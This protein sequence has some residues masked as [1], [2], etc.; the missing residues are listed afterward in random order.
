MIKGPL[1]PNER[2]KGISILELD[3]LFHAVLL[4]VQRQFASVIPD[5]VNDEETYSTFCLL[6][7]GA[8]SKAQNVKMD[9]TVINANNLWRK[10]MRAK[11]MKPG[12]SMME[13]YT[14]ADV[15]A[16]TLISFSSELPT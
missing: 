14:G 6:Q 3:V 13:Y 10:Q 4:G 5:H 16:P 7:R 8:S 2:G 12:M 15:T 1:F 9:E 11:G